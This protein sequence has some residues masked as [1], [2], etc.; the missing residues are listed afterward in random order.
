[1]F[2]DGAET[3]IY[4]Y[5]WYSVDKTKLPSSTVKVCMR[6]CE[7]VQLSKDRLIRTKYHC[8]ISVPQPATYVP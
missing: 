3:Y 4:S 5:D 2:V 8:S 7:D 1:M 6:S